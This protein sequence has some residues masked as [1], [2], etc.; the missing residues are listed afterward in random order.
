[1]LG[2]TLVRVSG[3]SMAP[4][5]RDGD[6]VAARTFGPTRRPSDGDIVL[7]D[8]PRLGL[9]VKRVC[10]TA[11]DGRYRLEGLAPE[12]T[13]SVALG[14]MPRD[15]LIARARWRIGPAGVSRLARP[16]PSTRGRG[17]PGP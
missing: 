3:G 4:L 1:M 16:R 5:L 17:A 7:V 9:I 11:T 6:Y 8:H 10:E 15:C 12:S 14:W 13:D 2:W